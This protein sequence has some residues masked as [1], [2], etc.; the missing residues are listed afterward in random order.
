MPVEALALL[1][2]ALA[3]SMT[4]LIWF[5]Q[6]VHYPLFLNVADAQWP[7]YHDAHTRRTTWVVAAPMVGELAASLLLAWMVWDG[8]LRWLGAG[9][10][11]CAVLLWAA[12]FLVQVPIHELLAQAPHRPSMRLLVESNWVRTALWT[13]RS[14]LSLAIV[15]KL[16]GAA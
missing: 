11:A 4:G 3:L 15:W 14:A 13:V 16:L 9:S 6:V 10:A 1:N 2:A 5:V 8:P 7:A 12:T